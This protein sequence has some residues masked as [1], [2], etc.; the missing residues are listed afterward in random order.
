M[1]LDVKASAITVAVVF[2]LAVFSVALVNRFF[3]GYGNGFLR[4]VASL[5]PGF[6]P[7]GMRAGL[8]GT[9]YAALD[10]A[11]T[12]AIVAWVYNWSLGRFGGGSAA[13]GAAPTA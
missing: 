6:H 8:V 12:G 5:Y 1:K 7:G 10:G 4:M 2:A 3:S 11:V 13:G 9:A